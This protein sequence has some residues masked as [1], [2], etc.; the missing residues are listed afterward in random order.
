MLQSLGFSMKKFALFFLFLLVALSASPI[1]AQSAQVKIYTTRDGLAGNVIT[2]L[3]FEPNG[4]AW[5]GTSEGVTRISD[6][7]WV[8]YTQ[9]HGLGDSFITAV[10]VGPDERAWLGTQSGG[11]AVIDT[12]F[13]RV[14][15]FQLDTSDIPSNFITAL[16]IDT[17][18]RV[19][20]G[21]LNQGLAY[22][23]AK[24]EAWTRYTLPTNS[25]TA[26]ALD[27]DQHPWVGTASGVYH[28]VDESWLR[29]TTVGNAAVRRID[30]LD[31]A[32]NLTTDTARYVLTDSGWRAQDGADEITTAL[33][34]AQLTDGQVIA[35]A[36]DYQ[37]RYWLGT[38]RGI[39]MLHKG[40]APTPPAPLPVVLIH[41]W[42]VVPADTLETGEFRFLKNY[43]DRDGIPMFYVRGVSPHNTLYQNA[44]VIRDEIARVKKETGSTKVNIVA[45]SMGGMNTRAYLETSAYADDVNRAIILGTPQA[46]VEVWKPILLQQIQEKFDEPSAIELSPEYADMVV[47]QTR[48]PNPNVPYDLLIGDARKQAGLGFLSDMPGSD[49]L[50]S[51]DSALALNAPTVREHVNSDLHDWGPQP[52]PI[53]LTGYLYPRDT[54]ERY[55]RNALRNSDNAPI[56]SEIATDPL[57]P[58]DLP[59]SNHTPVVTEKLY[60]GDPVTRTVTIDANTSARFVAYYP[61]GAVDF[62]LVAPDGKKYEPSVLPR[63]DGSG[64]LSLST[65]VASFSGYVVKNAP[66]GEWQIVL[67][68][69]DSG[70]DPVNVSTYV[71]LTSP[72]QM[73]LFVRTSLLAL[74]NSNQVNTWVFADPHSPALPAKFTASIAQPS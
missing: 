61:G 38:A 17:Q 7:G 47:N 2:A 6:D 51:V 30:A 71:E 52:V 1:S 45:F 54:W 18:Y 60:V 66:V 27:G 74:G 20:V 28:L 29:D 53:D 34:T 46:G 44:Q 19:W 72:I 55:L 26:L 73:A 33:E 8:S 36:K 13:K 57:P 70:I 4:S 37:S 11:I 65:D 56:G 3:A 22:Y 32:W 62:S 67:T 14:T 12:G 68:R 40:N 24:A 21:T 15:T 23:D 42:T 16:A 69:T 39:F 63:D 48:A 41:G 59:S 43:A 10:A 58:P 9:A 64:V 49:A 35:F 31:G 50:I 25:I 5:V